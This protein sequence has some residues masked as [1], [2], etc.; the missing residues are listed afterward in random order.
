MPGAERQIESPARQH[1]RDNP[2][3]AS[4]RTGHKRYAFHMPS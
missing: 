2:A 4:A 3:E 1:T